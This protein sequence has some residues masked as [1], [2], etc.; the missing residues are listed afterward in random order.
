MSKR[1][2]RII[3][4]SNDNAAHT[5]EFTILEVIAGFRDKYE[6]KDTE[7]AYTLSD[8][9]DYL[10]DLELNET[11]HFYEDRAKEFPCLLKRIQ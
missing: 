11:V 7:L 6:L 9:A 2:Y 10:M 1:K 5:F 8:A 3:S 4:F